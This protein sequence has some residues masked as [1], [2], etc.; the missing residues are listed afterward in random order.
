MKET[1]KYQEQLKNKINYIP[2]SPFVTWL[3]FSHFHSLTMLYKSVH[4]FK[5][6]RDFPLA[7]VFINQ[8][9]ESYYSA[10]SEQVKES[11]SITLMFTSS[12]NCSKLFSKSCP[13][14]YLLYSVHLWEASS[15]IFCF[16]PRL[17]EGQVTESSLRDFFSLQF[18]LS[19]ASKVHCTLQIKHS[20]VDFNEAMHGS[21]IQSSKTPQHIS[22]FPLGS[23][24]SLDDENCHQLHWLGN[25][26]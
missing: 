6:W 18:V 26:N 8:N 7:F 25:L 4:S 5:K 9:R 24:D 12:W 3:F 2:H 17:A 11:G 15:D 1:H 22:F 20:P 16:S 21:N 23:E 19:L 13:A 14:K 10:E